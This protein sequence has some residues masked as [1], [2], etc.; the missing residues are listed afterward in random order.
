MTHQHYLDY[1][2]DIWNEIDEHVQ[3]SWRTKRMFFD[4]T[5]SPR[6]F[7]EQE[8]L[9]AQNSLHSERSSAEK[10]TEAY[11][12][13]ENIRGSSVSSPSSAD[14]P[15]FISE[16][17]AEIRSMLRNNYQSMKR[18]TYDIPSWDGFRELCVQYGEGLS[19]WKA[20]NEIPDIELVNWN[21]KHGVFL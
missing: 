14:D 12:T 3:C 18:Y 17:A 7:W 4:K 16:K 2:L 6:Y 1:L 20:M 10:G 15:H 5:A 9:T 13:R 21:A 8:Q 19:Y 11:E